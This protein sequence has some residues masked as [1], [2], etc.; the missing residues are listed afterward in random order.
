MTT[1]QAQIHSQCLKVLDDFMAALNAHDAAGMDAQMH[2][3]H[4]RIAR[5]EVKVYAQAGSNPMD[6]FDKLKAEDDWSH[7]RWERRDLVQ[8]NEIK[9][10][11]AVSYT[12]YRSDGSVIGA[13][14]SLYIL[15]RE[16]RGW[17]ILARSSFGP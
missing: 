5:G 12:R 15:T 16:E 6:L 7:S 8:H 2:F 11:Y 9:A 10:H 4:V 17:G 14:E 1:Q 3:P 13:Y